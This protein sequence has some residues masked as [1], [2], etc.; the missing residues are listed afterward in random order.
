MWPCDRSLPFIHVKFGLHR[1]T[2]LG[3]DWY[4][5]VQFLEVCQGRRGEEERNPH[6]SFESVY[7]LRE[8]GKHEKWEHETVSTDRINLGKYT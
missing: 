3:T 2:S 6:R 8:D 7:F 5:L 4:R 1:E